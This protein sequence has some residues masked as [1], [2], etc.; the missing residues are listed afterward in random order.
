MEEQGAGP[1]RGGG[2]N[3][4]KGERRRGGGGG[5]G[6]SGIVPVREKRSEQEA[7]Y[8]EDGVGQ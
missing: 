4:G 1:R 3:R 2:A 5:K 8:E 7:R 6:Q